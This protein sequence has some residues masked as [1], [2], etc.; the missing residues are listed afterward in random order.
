MRSFLCLF[1]L[2][3]CLPFSNALAQDISTSDDS[4]FPQHSIKEE[5]MLFYEQF[6]DF[7]TLNERLYGEP[8]VNIAKGSRATNCRL[9]KQVYGYHPHWMDKYYKGY[10]YELLSTFIY[11]SYEL[12]PYNGKAKTTHRWK[13]H[14]SID[15]AKKAGSRVEL[16]VSNFKKHETFLN[17]SKSWSTLVNNLIALLKHRDGD[18]VNI[19]FEGIPRSQADNFT[20]FIKYLSNRLKSERPGSSVSVALPA[21]DWK[22]VFQM[23]KLDHYV[24]AFLIM[25]YDYHYRG[26]KNA[27]PVAPLYDDATWFNYSLTKSIDAY[28]CKVSNSQKIILAI[29]YYGYEWRTYDFKVPSK[30]QRNTLAKPRV[31]AEIQKKYVNKFTRYWHEPTATPYFITKNKGYRQCWYD[32]KESLSIKYDRVIDMDIGGVGIWA[33]GYDNGYT[34]LWNLLEEK[35]MSCGNAPPARPTPM[36]SLNNMSNRNAA[37][38]FPTTKVLAKTDTYQTDFEIDFEDKDKCD[39]GWNGRYYQVLEFNGANWQANPNSGFFHDDFDRK[40]GKWLPVSGQWTIDDGQL[41]QSDVTS[42]NTNIY[43]PL[44]QIGD[45]SYLYHFWAN[46]GGNSNNRRAGIHFFADDG[47]ASNRGNSYFVYFR[48]NWN[49]VELYKVVKN[50]FYRKIYKPFEMDEEYDY[51]FK[52]AYNPASGMIEIYIDNQLIINWQDPYPL[53]SGQYI[54]FRTAESTMNCDFLKVYKSRNQSAT[55]R[56]GTQN[57]NDI[58]YQS[59][60][61]TPSTARIVSIAKNAYNQWSA[62]DIKEVSVKF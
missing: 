42:S 7:D 11:F 53:Q 41:S 60:P 6:E 39:A 23:D 15:L 20:A 9:N 21:V 27:G 48:P 32:D 52:I 35:F 22:S 30:R 36:V 3:L 45:H 25:G 26:A 55:V 31:Y 2:Y 10:D 16:C 57:S 37:V 1:W 62:P 13:T 8:A 34:D 29:P 56:I 38:C 18:G 59:N 58:R 50:K 61:N 51:D 49:T 47:K 12:N 17:N 43:A 33:L 5:Q 28:T 54:S 4:D 24:D 44:K 19:D 46:I 14:P 40:H